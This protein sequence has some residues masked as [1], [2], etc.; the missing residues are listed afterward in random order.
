VG[1][2]A[3]G[4]VLIENG[5]LAIKKSSETALDRV[6]QDVLKK[7]RDTERNHAMAQVANLAAN[8]PDV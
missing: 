1:L 4:K 7:A 5:A 6:L 8:A 2:P 3:S